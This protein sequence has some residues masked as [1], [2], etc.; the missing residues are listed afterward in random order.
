MKTNSSGK[1]MHSTY[2]MGVDKT[3]MTWRWLIWGGSWASGR[4]RAAP[5]Y[6]DRS[7]AGRGRPLS[8]L[9]PDTSAGIQ[10]GTMWTQS[11]S[12]TLV[13]NTHFWLEISTGD[14]TNLLDQLDLL[15]WILQLY[16]SLQ[17]LGQLTD[18]SLSISNWQ[19]LWWEDGETMKEWRKKMNN[20]EHD[21][22]PKFFL[23]NSVVQNR[24]RLKLIVIQCKMWFN[25]KFIRI[26]NVSIDY[27]VS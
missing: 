23:N 7:P 8:A 14:Q 2:S 1:I 27:R 24:N 18:C 25:D 21:I 26:Y 11:G 9:H 12:L 16:T 13:R 20:F 6:A 4:R 15:H 22:H 3:R 5:G 10:P 19:T 17:G